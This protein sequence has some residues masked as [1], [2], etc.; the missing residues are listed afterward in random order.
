MPMKG[1]YL[2][3]KRGVVDRR[4]QKPLCFHSAT[5]MTNVGCVGLVGVIEGCLVASDWNKWAVGLGQG[6]NE[7]GI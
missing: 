2:L 6:E 5:R 7:G 4:I 3:V 1:C